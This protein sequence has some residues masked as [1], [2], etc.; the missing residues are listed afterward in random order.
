MH[1]LMSTDYQI[2]P[3]VLLICDIPASQRT[4]KE[5]LILERHFSD[6]YSVFLHKLTA[7][8]LQ[9]NVSK[10]EAARLRVFFDQL[11]KAREALE[12]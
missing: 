9:P 8:V 1:N 7:F 3:E 2:R 11:L 12:N 4:E 10:E 6:L 5:K